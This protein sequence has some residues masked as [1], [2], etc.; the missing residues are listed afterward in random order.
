MILENESAI[1]NKTQSKVVHILYLEWPCSMYHRSGAS[2]FMRGLVEFLD[3]KCYCT[4]GCRLYLFA[5][6]LFKNTLL[7]NVVIGSYL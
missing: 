5:L 4:E 7:L 2:Y 6:S 3:P 1:G